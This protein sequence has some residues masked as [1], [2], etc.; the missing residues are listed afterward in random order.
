MGQ[1]DISDV[2]FYEYDIDED[3]QAGYIIDPKSDEKEVFIPSPPTKMIQKINPRVGVI[4]VTETPI[5]EDYENLDSLKAYAKEKK[6]F[7]ACPE[8]TD[9]DALESIYKYMQ[10]KAKK[11]N[12]KKDEIVVQYL[13]NMENAA[14]EFVDYAIDELDADL[15]DAEEFEF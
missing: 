7:I 15:D 5:T 3:G 11:L 4:L 12:I 14:Q 2:M 1:I 13:G 8:E 10:S 6:V 9:V